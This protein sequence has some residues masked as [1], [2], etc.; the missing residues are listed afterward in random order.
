MVTYHE[1]VALTLG[2]IGSERAVEPLIAYTVD[3]P[4]GGEAGNAASHEAEPRRAFKGRVGAIIGLG[5]LAN[6]TGSEAALGFLKASVAPAEWDARGLELGALA[7]GSGTPPDLELSR[8]AIIA[9]GLSGRPE[10]AETLRALAAEPATRGDGPEAEVLD[11][12]VAQ[13]LELFG[14]IEGRGLLEY[15]GTDGE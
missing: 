6:Q 8:Y 12:A 13:G 9:L 3:G 2:M 14:E 15:Y 5:Y 7:E 1:N 4:A 11:G 10:A